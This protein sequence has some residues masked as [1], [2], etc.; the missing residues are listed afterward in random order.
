LVDKII[1]VMVVLTEEEGEF[2]LSLAR[3]ALV[4][5]IALE[6]E[7][8]VTLPP[9]FREPRGVFVTLKRNDELRGCIGYPYP[10]YPLEK[11]LRSAAIAAATEDPRFPPVSPDELED[12]TIEVTILTPPQKLLCNA[13]E[14]HDA[15]EV[16][17]HGIIIAGLGCQGLLLPQVATEYEWD[18]TTFLDHTCMKAGLPPGSWTREDTE[19][20]VFE[21]QIF[22]EQR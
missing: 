3:R 2:A 19:V 7:E 12:L 18:S 9:V 11:A 21:G 8:S 17:R 13:R 20:M 4:E 14:R 16:G 6:P 15:I 5:A 10:I 22:R 1:I